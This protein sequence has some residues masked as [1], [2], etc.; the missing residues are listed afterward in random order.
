MPRVGIG[1][2]FERGALAAQAA[3]LPELC[4][5]GY[6]D[7]WTQ[8]TA[9]FDAFGPALVAALAAPGARIGTCVAGVFA[10]GPGLLAL[11]AAALADL[12][13]GRC[14]VGIG[15]SSPEIVEGWNA[16]RFE[17]PVERVRDTLSFLRRALAGERID[18]EFASFALRG[19]R[20]EQPPAEPPPL[21]A[22]ALRPRMLR[23][24]AREADGICLALLG[25]DDVPRVLAEA[26]AAGEV[27][28]VVLGIPVCPTRDAGRVRAAARALLARYLSLPTYARFH[29]WLGREDALTPVWRALRAGD[30]RAA[31]AAVPDA[32]VDALFVHGPL[33]AC[34]EQL[35]RFTA[36]GVTTPVLSIWSW[37]GDPFS[38]LSALAPG[39]SA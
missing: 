3:R 26:R 14:V 33:E 20:L 30:R 22:A 16:A 1:F 21:Y 23:L 39:A 15:S 35:A 7:V 4:A 29:A 18:A 17:R 25:P 19:F 37:D 9:R 32:L 10:R 31:E 5:R 24:A 11:Q 13:P 34:R 8:E 2:P 12:A 38:A 28:D 36:A 27:R 6:T